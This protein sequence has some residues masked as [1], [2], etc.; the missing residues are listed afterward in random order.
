[1]QGNVRYFLR[2]FT[3]QN[4]CSKLFK[5]LIFEFELRN[6]VI[7]QL[8][9]ALNYMQLLLPILS[10]RAHAPKI[11]SSPAFHKITYV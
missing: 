9:Q 4:L 7:I 3:L 6:F 11:D 8:K 2:L 5:I 1:M 10:C